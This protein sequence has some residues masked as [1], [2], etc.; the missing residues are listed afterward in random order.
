MREKQMPASIAPEGFQA[1]EG[2]VSGLAPKLS[3]PLEATLILPTSRFNSSAAERLAAL[4]GGLI[5]QSMAMGLKIFHFP[6][7]I[8]AALGPQTLG[9]LLQ[10]SNHSD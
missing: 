4:F 10:F 2:F 6:S 3:G 7:C 1:H 5:V 9:D 8:R